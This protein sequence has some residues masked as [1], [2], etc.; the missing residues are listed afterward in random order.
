[1]AAF[2]AGCGASGGVPDRFSGTWRV[3]DGR[4]IPIRRVAATPGAAALRKLGGRPCAGPTL[5]FQATYFGGGARLVGCTSADG[6]RLRA[7]FDDNGVTG[8]IDQRVAGRDRFVASVRGDGH[9]PFE[10][11]A[12]RVSGH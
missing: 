8:E 12:R 5:Y 11:V 2:L 7:R 9:A 10:I 3:A 1:V 4:T 6:K